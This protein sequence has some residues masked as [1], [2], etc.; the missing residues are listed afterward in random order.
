MYVTALVPYVL[1]TAILVR[2]LTLEGSVDGIIYYLK[3]DLSRLSDAR[4]WM[5]GGTQVLYSIG[6][7]QGYMFGLGSYNKFH[8]N[9]FRYIAI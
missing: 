7:G 2:G 8:D 6:I 3:P 5:D 4:V 1:L 9:C